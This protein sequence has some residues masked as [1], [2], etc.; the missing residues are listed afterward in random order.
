MKKTTKHF[1]HHPPVVISI[2]RIVYTNLFEKA[3][4]IKVNL[5]TYLKVVRINKKV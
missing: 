5:L 1:D 3:R 2:K 4:N